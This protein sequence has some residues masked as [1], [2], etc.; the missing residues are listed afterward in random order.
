MGAMRPER[1]RQLTKLLADQK[2]TPD[3]VPPAKTAAAGR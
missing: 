3:L 2:K 1:A